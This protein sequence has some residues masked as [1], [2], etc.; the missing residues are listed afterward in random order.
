MLIKNFFSV[1]ASC[2]V[3]PW[4]SMGFSCHQLALALAL[5]AMWNKT[6]VSTVWSVNSLCCRPPSGSLQE[7]K[8][9]LS[10]SGDLC[11]LQEG[12]PAPHTCK[13]LVWWGAPGPWCSLKQPLWRGAEEGQSSKISL[14]FS[15]GWTWTSRQA[16]WAPCLP[17]PRGAQEWG[18]S[19]SAFSC[20][21]S[22]SLL[23]LLKVW[24]WLTAKSVT[25]ILFPWLCFPL[26]S[27]LLFLSPA[28]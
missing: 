20:D 15:N 24:V 6:R 21:A 10:G 19:S 16:H 14:L 28:G 5:W 7:Q 23:M 17:L 18:W 4:P 13:N 3:Q 8:P 11:Q 25:Q 22:E 9:G 12:Q 2:R 27:P 26:C 1:A